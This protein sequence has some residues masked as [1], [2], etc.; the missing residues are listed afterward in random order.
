MESAFIEL[1]ILLCDKLSDDEKTG[2]TYKEIK[3]MS[4]LLDVIELG[5]TKDDE[6]ETEVN[7]DHHDP[8]GYDEVQQVLR[9]FLWSNVQTGCK[10]NF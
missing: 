4:K 10:F 1:G 7:S 8:I 5:R 3:Q 9:S 2:I 6:E